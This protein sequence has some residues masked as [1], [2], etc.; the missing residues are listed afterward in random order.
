MS[1]DSKYQRASKLHYWFKSNSNFA[2]F[3][4]LGLKITLLF[5]T[6]EIVT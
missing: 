4:S 1:V 3:C 5:C 2:E 6:S